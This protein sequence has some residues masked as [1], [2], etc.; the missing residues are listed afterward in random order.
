MLTKDVEME[1]KLR[2]EA[3]ALLE[4]SKV[5]YIIGFEAGSLKSTTTPLITKDTGDTERLV[6]NP[7][8]VNNLAA[9]LTELEG[10]IGIVAK[11]CDSRSIVS[12]I[13]DNK[14][15]REDVV[16]IGVPCP[17]LIDLSKIEKLVGKDRDELDEIIREGDKV[18]VTV[19]GKKSE[20]SAAEV[21]YD[22]CLGCE[23]PTPQEYDIL[24]DEPTY[25]AA[26]KSA[27][28]AKIDQLKEITPAQRWEFWKE[29]FNRCIRC[30]ACRNICPACF[31]ERCFVE[32][33][34]PQWL[35]PIPRWQENL[36]FQ[37]IRNIHVAGRCTDCGE[38]ERVCPVNIP[39]RSLTKEMYD[40]VGDLFQFKSG[41]DKDAPSLM[42]HYEQEEAEDFIR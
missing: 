2:N 37:V 18:T 21:L 24:L 36:M 4:Q 8:I 11:G 30:Y 6:I 26:K 32:E 41:M 42:T 17:G 5:D 3:K 10:R 38:C 40:I 28:Q 27:S 23:L 1:Q 34:E 33:S 39:L 13:Q 16:I 9:F 14:V 29:Q 35:L 25:P 31:C 19:D 20:F 12:L 22:N 15:A 7:F